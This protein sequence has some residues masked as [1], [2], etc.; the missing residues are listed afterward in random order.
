MKYAVLAGLLLAQSA[1]KENKA[2]EAKQ[3][4]KIAEGILNGTIGDNDIASCIQDAEAVYADAQKFYQDFQAKD[5][6]DAIKDA[7]DLVQ[8]VENAITDC[9]IKK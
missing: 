2:E 5:Y 1:A 7:T 4:V 9:G 3:Y 8:Q 6:P